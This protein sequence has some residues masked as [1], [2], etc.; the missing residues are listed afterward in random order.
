MAAWLR[1]LE[2]L[3]IPG[4]TCQTLAENPGAIRFFERHGFVRHGPTPVVPGLRFRGQRV[5]Q[6]TMVR[7]GA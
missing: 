4:C 7:P 2:D 5:H 1:Q 3:G 6:Q